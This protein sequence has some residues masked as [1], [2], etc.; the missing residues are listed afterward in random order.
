MRELVTKVYR[1]DELNDTAKEKAIETQRTFE[2]EFNDHWHEFSIEDWVS[3]LSARGFEGA[4]ISFSGFWSQGDGASFTAQI[5]L[6]KYLKS[7]KLANKFKSVAVHAD[8]ITARVYRTSSRYVHENTV[9]VELEAGWYNQNEKLEAQLADLE[10]TILE[11][12]R[13]TSNQIYKDLEQDWDYFI[14]DEN[15]KEIIES[16]NFEFTAEGK[17]I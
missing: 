3:E 1:F 16:N 13:S 7:R 4:E 12:V 5:D 14:A 17:S 2:N 11:D 6:N 10:K 15:I 8:E 9:D